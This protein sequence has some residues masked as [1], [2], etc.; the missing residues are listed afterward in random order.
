[1]T[2]TGASG[3]LAGVDPEP[4]S[5]VRA[6]LGE[7]PTWDASTGTLRFVDITG[8]RVYRYDPIRKATASIEL[9]QEVGAVVPRRG[10]G[11]IAAVRDGI[12]LVEERPVR[13]EVVAEVEADNPGNRM[14][15]A[16]CDSRGRLWAGTMALAETPGA[17][18]LY[19]YD[20]DGTVTKMVENVTISNGLGWSADDRTM[21]YV[22]S[23]EGIDAFDFDVES[24]QIGNR[25]RLA[26]LDPEL[27]EP[28]GMTVDSAGYLW[29]AIWGGSC[30][31][32]YAPSGELER[33]IRMPVSQVTSVAFGGPDLEDLYIT[34]ARTG[35]T[36]EQLEREPLAGAC[37]VCRPGVKG[38]HAHPFAG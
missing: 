19:R 31:H 18:C 23:S 38:N 11:L 36:T 9:P 30:V 21:Y 3:H 37:F 20:V 7:G 16:K 10:G 22:D 33:E 1:V 13:F 35:L 6:D 34:S 15:D 5:A 24:G 29:V 27:G 28:D 12:A 26:S 17:G 8:R 25:R 14:N 2:A 4:I 32:R